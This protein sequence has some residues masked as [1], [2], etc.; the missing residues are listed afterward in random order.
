MQGRV[1][2]ASTSTAVPPLARPGG[3]GYTP[4]QRPA[5]SWWSG[6]LVVRAWK[7]AGGLWA[8]HGPRRPLCPHARY[9]ISSV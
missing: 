9:D 3:E 1:V 5:V 2:T 6:F 4:W 7:A 8:R